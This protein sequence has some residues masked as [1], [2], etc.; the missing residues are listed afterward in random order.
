M[1]PPKTG[2]SFENLCDLWA[3]VWN[4]PHTQKNDRKGQPKNGVDVYGETKNNNWDGVQAKEKDQL[5]SKTISVEELHNEVEK[6]KKF[7]PALREYII[8]TTEPRDGKIQKEARK[9]T[10]RNRKQGFFDVYVYSWEDIEALLKKHEDVYLQTSLP[11]AF[12]RY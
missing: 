7:S 8:A 6:A 2:K 1:P 4:Y 5:P 11:R 10:V 12:S 9:I 3:E